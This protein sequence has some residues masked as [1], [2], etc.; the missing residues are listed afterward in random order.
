MIIFIDFYSNG[1]I[2]LTIIKLFDFFKTN[3]FGS[4]CLIIDINL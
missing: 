4:S 3:L 1:F 2:I